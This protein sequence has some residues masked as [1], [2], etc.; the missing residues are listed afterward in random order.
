M[1]LSQR[2]DGSKE[3]K[4][5]GSHHEVKEEEERREE[6][7]ERPQDKGRESVAGGLPIWSYEQSRWNIVNRK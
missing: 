1:D 3:R 6:R 2:E 5:Q 7:G 4:E